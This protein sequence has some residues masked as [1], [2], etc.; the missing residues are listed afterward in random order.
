MSKI[1]EMKEN[2]GKVIIG[3]EEIVEL[4][5][6]AVVAKGH[7]LLEDVPGTGKTML[8]KALAKSIDGEFA[9][10][11]FTPDLLPSD[12]TG[13]N[14]YN[15]SEGEFAFKKGP[16]FSNILL[17]DEINRATPR[18]QAGLLESMEERQVSVDGVIYKLESPFFV[19][20]TQNPLETLGTFPLPEAQLDRFLMKL[21]MGLPGKEEEVKM[22]ERF[23]S[24]E[25]LDELTAVASKEDV[26]QLQKQARQVY[27]HPALIDYMAELVQ[28]SRKHHQVEHGI[29]PRGT[30]AL[31]NSARA[32]ALVKGREYVVP[33]DIK[34]VAVPVLAHRIQ[35]NTSFQKDVAT[36]VIQGLLSTVSLPT[37]DWK[38]R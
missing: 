26:L 38:S 24:K 19:I 14:Y 17:A 34:T 33:E 28:E 2:I 20:A 9:R 16:V 35:T 7:V 31:L 37:E 15:Q 5:L 6:T 3:K 1:A 18:T 27:V 10:V 8:A 30:L 36:G 22:M 11:Q 29:S 32:Y 23:M 4:V 13:I 12:I 25:P 21:S